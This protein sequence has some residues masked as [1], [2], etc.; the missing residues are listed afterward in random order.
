MPKAKTNPLDKY[1]QPMQGT[2]KHWRQKYVK[3]QADHIEAAA[4]MIADGIC[5]WTFAGM[6]RDLSN[7]LG[8]SVSRDLIR[9]IVARLR[10]GKCQ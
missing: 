7:E 6:A 1:R 5:T 8:V 9:D 10:D 2:V 3:E 4:K